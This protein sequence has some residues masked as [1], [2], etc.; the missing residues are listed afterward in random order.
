MTD[1]LKFIYVMIVCI[2]LF[3]VLSVISSGEPFS[4]IFQF[5]YFPYALLFYLLSLTLSNCFTSQEELGLVMLTNIVFLIFVI[6]TNQFVLM[7]N[8]F[9]TKLKIN[10]MLL[11]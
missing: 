2:F 11:S 6:L 4:T 7:V 8:V 10:Y 1:I 9:A 3:F 5:F